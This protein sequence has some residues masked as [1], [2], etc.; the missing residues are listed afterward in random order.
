MKLETPST[1]F[2]F[3]DSVFAERNK[4]SGTIGSYE[5][6]IQMLDLSESEQN[7]YLQ[8]DQ[9]DRFRLRLENRLRKTKLWNFAPEQ[10]E[11]VKA[12]RAYLQAF[13]GFEMAYQ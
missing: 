6:A 3:I 4:A 10:R 5:E 12:A 8:V 13:L 1:T 9:L 2:P 7:L 11:Q